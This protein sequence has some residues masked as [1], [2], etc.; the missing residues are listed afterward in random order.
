[1]WGNV[2]TS[3]ANPD[4]LAKTC[5]TPILVSSWD[6]DYSAANV[7]QTCLT[8]DHAANGFHNYQQ[9]MSRWTDIVQAGNGTDI[10]ANRP[11]GVFFFS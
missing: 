4:Y 10:Q 6:K 1:M 2:K 3:F 9:F 11:Q 7:G 5:Q 8:I